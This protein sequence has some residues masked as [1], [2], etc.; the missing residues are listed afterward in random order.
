MKEGKELGILWSREEIEICLSVETRFK[1][2]NPPNW[3]NVSFS[4]IQNT[5]LLLKAAI[6]VKWEILLIFLSDY[7]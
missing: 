3:E 1:G 5:M 2:E 6:T 4:W 7:Y